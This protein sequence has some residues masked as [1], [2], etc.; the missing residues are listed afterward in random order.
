MVEAERED[1]E[2]EEGEK[3]NWLPGWRNSLL[4]WVASIKRLRPW[5][6]ASSSKVVTLLAL[7]LSS[8]R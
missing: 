5:I 3:R 2:E 6:C 8:L 7:E 1:E 4:I